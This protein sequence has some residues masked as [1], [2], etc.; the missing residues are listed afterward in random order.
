MV[1]EITSLSEFERETSGPGLIVVDFFTTWCGPCKKIAPIIEQFSS[2]Y[3]NVKFIKVD[4]EQN[5]D[6]AGPRNIQ[7]IPTFHFILN[8][9]VK[10]EMKGADPNAL[11]QKVQELQVDLAPPKDPKEMSIKELMKVIRDNNLASKAVGLN[12]KNEFV[13]LVEE[14]LASKAK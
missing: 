12:E 13:A 7:S 14:F 8:G 10:Y 9:E 5:E 3:P 11:E 2:Q 6:I 4:I 1:K